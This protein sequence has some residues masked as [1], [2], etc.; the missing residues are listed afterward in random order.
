MR[1]KAIRFDPRTQTI[2]DAIHEADQMMYQY[3]E[4]HH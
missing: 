1:A 2:Q 4:A 3:K